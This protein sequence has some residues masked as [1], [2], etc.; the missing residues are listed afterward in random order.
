MLNF[1]INSADSLVL[2]VV[3]LFIGFVTAVIFV[4]PRG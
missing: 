3:I 2:M 1:L 4:P